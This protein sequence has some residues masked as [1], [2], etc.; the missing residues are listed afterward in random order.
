MDYEL[1]DCGAFKKI[2]KFGKFII[3]RPCMQ[4]VWPISDLK[5]WR[6]AHSEFIRS[7]PWKGVPSSWVI[8]FNELNIKLVPTN[9]GHLGVFPEHATHWEWMSRHLQ[10]NN[11]VLNLFAYTGTSTLY[12]AKKGFKVCHL[13]SAKNMIDWG[14]E[15]AKLNSLTTAPVRWI[16]DDATAFLKK[17]VKRQRKYDAVLLDPPSFGRGTKGQI[18]KIEKDLPILLGLI[19]KVLRKEAFLL[20]T[21]HTPGF[22]PIILE[23]LV[24]HFFPDLKLEKGE[25]VISSKNTSLP[26]GCYLR[27]VFG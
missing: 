9:F 21:C 15:N 23:N 24:Q 6:K 7:E 27:G 11:E 10:K 25:M 22:S 26:S 16:V 1:L 3:T 13:D 12:L 4:A 17:E 18:F 19:K 5:I 8:N 14:K 20:L 2:E